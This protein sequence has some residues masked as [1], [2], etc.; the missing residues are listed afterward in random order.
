MYCSFPA[1]LSL[2]HM[3]VSY[4]YLQARSTIRITRRRT[5]GAFPLEYRDPTNDAVKMILKSRG[6]FCCVVVSLKNVLV[7]SSMIIMPFQKSRMLCAVVLKRN[8]AVIWIHSRK[9]KV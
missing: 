4:F 8:A 7:I 2:L 5:H 3:S 1:Q 6:R 9:T